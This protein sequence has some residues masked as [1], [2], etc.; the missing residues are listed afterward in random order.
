MVNSDCPYNQACY[1]HHC[2][3]PCKIG[4]VCG[5]NAVC[6]TRDHVATC[7]CLPDYMGNAFVQCI[8]R[9]KYNIKI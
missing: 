5:V 9:R 4:N 7:S 8:T 2:T 6:T 3:D 1:D